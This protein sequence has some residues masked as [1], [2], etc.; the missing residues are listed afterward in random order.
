MVLLCPLD[1]V[2]A[3]F[4]PRARQEVQLGVVVDDFGLHMVGSHR[5]VKSESASATIMLH[6]ELEKIHLPVHRQKSRVLAST[7]SLRH[8]LA[9][10]LSFRRVLAVQSERYL[11]VDYAAGGVIKRST[12]RGRRVSAAARRRR[13]VSIASKLRKRVAHHM[14]R[15]AVQAST[16][17]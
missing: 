8:E 10:A 3:A 5:P 14:V 6:Q 9:V 4:V 13:I 1:T 17:H 15:A 2:Q 11:G 7:P 12:K 16:A